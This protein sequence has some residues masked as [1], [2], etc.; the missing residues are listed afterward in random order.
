MFHIYRDV[1]APARMQFIIVVLNG[2]ANLNA[3]HG[4][5]GMMCQHLLFY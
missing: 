5:V 4:D 1:L 3:V 2:Y